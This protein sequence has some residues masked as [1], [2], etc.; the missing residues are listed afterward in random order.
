MNDFGVLSLLPPIL[1]IVLA[2]ITKNVLFSLFCGIFIGATMLAGWNPILGFVNAI[3]D[4]IIPNMGDTW[5]AGV[6]LMTLF[7]GVF[8]ALLERGGGATAFGKKMENRIH[9]RKQA[10]IAAWIGG[11]MIFFSDSSNS[12]IVGPIFKPITD[13]VKVSREKL[14]YICD[15]TAATIPVLI[16]ITAWGALIF[17]IIKDHLPEGT[18]LMSVFVKSIPF[19]IYPILAIIMVFYIAIT[20]WDFGS[21]RK[22]EKRAYEEG[23]V[24][25]D[26]AQPLK[27]D[28]NL[29]IPKGSNPTIWDMIIPLIVL[30]VSLFAVFLWTGGFP[31]VGF[32]EAISNS[33][34]MLGLS[35][36]FFLGSIAASIMTKRSKVMTVKQIG[37]T[38]TIGFSQM[39]E[40]ILILILS[41]SIGSVVTKVGTA[42]FIVRVTKGLITPGVMF[43]TIFVSACLTSFATGTSWGTFAIFL[44]IAIPL[45]LENDISVFPAIGAALAGGLFGDH[46]SPISDSTILASLGASCDHLDHV[47]T[48]SPYAIVCAIASICGYVVAAITNNGFLSLAAGLVVMLAIV[49][50]LNKLEV[51]RENET[52][53]GH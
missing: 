6:I 39:I 23:K 49:F 40:A 30:I 48:Q 46:C 18:N 41:W 47:K 20:G 45:A 50:V 17:G 13:R 8:A 25:S 24:L 7:V 33:D 26:N 9:T 52:V 5:N 34:S 1:A 19:D 51:N 22:A 3:G 16:P 21:M 44:P 53:K 11:L 27:K 28:F 14:A 2:F 15:S 36:A 12:V 29:D 10:Q 42:D 31:E 37:E 38:W 32:V 35:V 43:I 4:F